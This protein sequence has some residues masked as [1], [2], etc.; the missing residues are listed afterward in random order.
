MGTCQHGKSAPDQVLEELHE[1]QEGH[2]RHKCAECA[3]QAGVGAGLGSKH[4]PGGNAECTYTGKRAP[5]DIIDA[6]PESQAGK[7]RHKCAICAFHHGHEA[8]RAQA[9]AK[10]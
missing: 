1:G 4:S 9:V 10:S 7:G 8:G 2:Q 5:E 3:Y 6:L